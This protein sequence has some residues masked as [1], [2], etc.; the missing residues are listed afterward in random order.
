MSAVF[1]VVVGPGRYVEYLEALPRMSVLVG[2]P[3]GNVGLSAVSPAL[4]LAGVVFAYVATIWAGLRLDPGRGAALAIAA[5]LLAQPS[6]GF[7]YAGLLL[8]G[9]RHALVGR[10]RRR[11]HRGPRDADRRGRRA[12][13]SRRSS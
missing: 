11:V 13:R 9:G 3:S 2:L 10:P 8:P 1:A 4:A 6:I 7:N 12:R 5:C